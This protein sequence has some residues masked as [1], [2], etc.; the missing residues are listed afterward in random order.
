[1]V[2]R[3]KA[4]LKCMKIIT[5]EDTLHKMSM[6]C[7]PPLGGLPPPLNTVRKRNPSPTPSLASSASSSPSQY[8]QD[9]PSPDKRGVLAAA[10][11]KFGAASPQAVK[12]LLSLSEQ[13][14]PRQKSQLTGENSKE[15][16]KDA[17]RETSEQLQ[18]VNTP[19]NLTKESSS[20]SAR[21]KSRGQQANGCSSQGRNRS[22]SPQLPA[23]H[24][25]HPQQYHRHQHSGQTLSVHHAI[26]VSTICPGS[27]LSSQAWGHSSSVGGRLLHQGGLSIIP[28][29][30]HRGP[31][32]APGVPTP[33][34]L[35]SGPEDED[36][37]TQVSAV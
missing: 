17:S 36:D 15:S 22:Q 2:R 33:Y 18:P 28:R 26:P 31:S 4:Y 27:P 21:P 14:R 35:H 1:M 19:V 34:Y 8:S 7:E 11:N 12:K 6:E 3:V 30:V 32:I 9:P 16:P 13:S 29:V 10:P 37:E 20:V 25:R 24:R 23:R 5:D